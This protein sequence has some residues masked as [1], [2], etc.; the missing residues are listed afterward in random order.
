MLFPFTADPSFGCS[1]QTILIIYSVLQVDIVTDGIYTDNLQSN[2]EFDLINTTHHVQYKSKTAFGVFTIKVKRKPMH[3]LVT[4]LF[5]IIMLAIL[6]I[7]VF[8]LPCDY[9]EKISYA[10]T[11]FLA[12][13]VTLTFIAS[14]L[15]EN[16]ETTAYLSVY[17]MIQTAQSTLETLIAIVLVRLNT[18]DEKETKPPK[19]LAFLAKLLTCRLCPRR[20]RKREEFEMDSNISDLHDMN[21]LTFLAKLTTCRLCQR[22]KR[23]RV[24]FKMDSN[25]S[26]L[27]DKDRHVDHRT[28]DSYGRNGLE[29]YD[30]DR[31]AGYRRFDQ[32]DRN[33][34]KI[35]RSSN[36]VQNHT[37]WHPQQRYPERQSERK[38]DKRSSD[39]DSEDSSKDNRLETW[40][41]VVAGLDVFF[42]ILFTI[43]FVA[44]TIHYVVVC[45]SGGATE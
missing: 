43:T 38:P 17:V 32:F 5:P 7:F 1:R 39:K 33:S 40:K 25:I 45:A 19:L 12:F 36:S 10:I 44:T 28:Y 42:F 22:R 3:V 23:N 2:S 11:V 14:T 29:L 30:M 31:Q 16:S 15:P 13:M 41:G 27:H 35:S 8:V 6:N 21:R 26:D 9:G 34:S 4:A 24:E 20:R 18:F 37:L